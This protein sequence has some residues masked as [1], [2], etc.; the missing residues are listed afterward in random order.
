MTLREQALTDL[1]AL[2]LTGQVGYGPDEKTSERTIADLLNTPDHKYSRTPIREALAILG[3][4]GMV[5]HYP[6]I[7]VAVRPVHASEVGELARLIESIVGA[8]VET[9]TANPAAAGQVKDQTR[10][11]F[12]HMGEAEGDDSAHDFLLAATQ[13][14]VI[15][16]R[17][18]GYT[19][20]ATAVGTYLDR[21]HLRATRYK[22]VDQSARKALS[23]QTRYL[24]DAVDKQD[25][26]EALDALRY[27]LTAYTGSLLAHDGAATPQSLT[28]PIP[29][30]LA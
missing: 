2:I 14:Y 10:E 27:F 18:A 4:L 23:C 13:L 20:G 7:G 26:D 15:L 21:L 6:Q 5:Q 9:L 28:V 1:R 30:V 8:A 24:L 11:S 16:V 25:L 3:Q 22:A 12:Q 17:H 29:I 19:A